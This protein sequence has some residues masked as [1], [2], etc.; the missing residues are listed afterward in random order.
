MQD[1]LEND[2]GHFK[3][4]E[5]IKENLKMEIEKFNSLFKHPEYFIVKQ[6]SELKR[7]VTTEKEKHLIIYI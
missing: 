5:R 7:Q 6:I 1:L 3:A 2:L 4:L